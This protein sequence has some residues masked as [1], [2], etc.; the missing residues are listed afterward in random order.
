MNLSLRINST[1][2]PQTA[3][4]YYFVTITRILSIVNIL[5]LVSQEPRVLGEVNEIL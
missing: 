2:I 3:I 5:W 1:T 4:V